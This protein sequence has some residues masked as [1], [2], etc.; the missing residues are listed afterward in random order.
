[1]VSGM[2]SL[3]EFKQKKKK[4]IGNYCLFCFLSFKHIV[5]EYHYPSQW[6]VYKG[7][8]VVTFFGTSHHAHQCIIVSPQS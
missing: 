2:F 6:H 8:I 3:V 1:M 5:C 7:A 4:I